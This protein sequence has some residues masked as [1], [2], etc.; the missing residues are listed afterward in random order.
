LD[1]AEK[2]YREILK[3][4]ENNV[5]TLGNLAAI[6]VEQRRLEEGEVLLQRALRLDPQDP[7][8]LSLLG[9]VRF[10]QQ[11]YDEAFEALSRSAQIDPDNDETQNYLGITLSQRGQ[12]QAAEAALRRA[13]KLNP[14]SASAH[15]NIAVV[16]A[17][18]KPPFRE[19][20]RYHYEKSRRAGQPPSPAFERLLRGEDAAPT[21]PPQ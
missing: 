1:E 9:I 16:Y 15:Y 18:Q 17:T 11:R 20:A 14:A 5:F 7:F 10:R 21:A 3:L 4:D 8:S 19:L 13:L 2:A 6:V 12:R